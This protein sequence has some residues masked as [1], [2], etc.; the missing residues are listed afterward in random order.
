MP[1]YA[2]EED[3]IFPHPSEAEEDGLLAVGGDLSAERL[4][5]AYANGI[6]PWYADDTPILWWSPN[7]RMLLFPQDFILRKSLKQSINKA[8]YSMRCDTAF[9][10]VIRECRHIKRKDEEGTWIT[11]EMQEAYVQLHKLGFAHSVEVFEDNNLVGGLYGLS[12]GAAFFGESMFSKTT[13]SSKIALYYFCRFCMQHAFE[14]IDCQMYTEHLSRLGA[15][16]IPQEDFLQLLAQAMEKT[17]KKG[18]WTRAFED[19]LEKNA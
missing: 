3:L 1:V 8:R 16:E 12:L 4:L 9:E 15:K 19:F 11:D 6:F 18:A 13:D 7:P 17:T 14:F 5:L 10:Q 2:L